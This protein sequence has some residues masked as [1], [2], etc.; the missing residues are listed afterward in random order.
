MT[1]EGIFQEK[2]KQE[3]L[4]SDVYMSQSKKTETD[5]FFRTI[6][7]FNQEQL[8]RSLTLCG[9]GSQTLMEELLG[10]SLAHKP[11]I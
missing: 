1:K 10:C 4:N 3:E 11:G 7:T 5:L 6:P 9:H 2:H 8:S